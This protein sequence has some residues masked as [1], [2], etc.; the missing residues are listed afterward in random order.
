M[1]FFARLEA[2]SFSWG[3]VDL[4][5]RSGIAADS[6]FSR[7]DAENA[8]SAQF[9]ALTGCQGLLEAFEHGVHCRFRLGARQSCALDHLMNDILLDQWSNLAAPADLTV[10]PPTS[11]IVQTLWELG[12]R[13]RVESGGFSGQTVLRPGIRALEPAV[14]L[15]AE[16]SGRQSRGHRS[17]LARPR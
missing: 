2:N 13:R 11:L 1:Q 6:S 14:N 5:P 4:G 7:A 8:E 15:D 17:I 10:E 9:D 12:N 3:N 16:H